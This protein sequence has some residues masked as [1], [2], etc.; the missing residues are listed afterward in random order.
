[1]NSL[2]PYVRTVCAQFKASSFIFSIIFL[3]FLHL[4]VKIYSGNLSRSELHSV[5]FLNDNTGYLGGNGGYFAKTTNSGTDWEIITTGFPDDILDICVLGEETFII[6]C[7]TGRIL[8]TTD[9]GLSWEEKLSGLNGK[10]K[11]F[12]HTF[13]NTLFACGENAILIYSYN[14][15]ETWESI[16]INANINLNKIYFNSFSTGIIACSH[17][18]ILLTDNGG[19]SWTLKNMAQFKANFTGIDMVDD[20][21]GTIVSENGMILNTTNNWLTYTIAK[22]PKGK[23]NIYDIKYINDSDAIAS[24]KNFILK[25][26]NCGSDWSISTM[27]KL[28]DGVK[29]NSITLLS[30]TKAIVAGGGVTLLTVDEGETWD[31]SGSMLRNPNIVNTITP[32]EIKLNQNF[33]NPFNPSTVISFTLPENAY[34]SLKIY[35]ITGKEM[36]IIK[37]GI[38]PT[39]DH[40]VSFNASSLSSGVYFYTLRTNINGII[41]MKTMRMLLIK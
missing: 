19:Y 18:Y 17:G 7:N 29:L 11:S 27:P 36:A 8:K 40:S 9:G 4:P 6:G 25:S 41:S 28:A 20:K 26:T 1:M 33:P 2:Q 13:D 10:V 16:T 35:D 23:E 12:Y 30:D 22:T 14:H 38:M 34:V 24:G 5:K 15:G 21:S 31:H 37:D 32:N 3:L 39:G